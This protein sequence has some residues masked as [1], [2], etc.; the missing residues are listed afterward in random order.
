MRRNPV[1]VFKDLDSVGIYN[2]PLES[3]VQINDADANGD[4]L[5][6]QIEN[7]QGIGKTSTIRDFLQIEE[8]FTR[9]S[10]VGV[11]SDEEKGIPNGVAPLDDRALIP[12]RYI[13]VVDINEVYVVDSEAEMI[14][15]NANSG[16]M[17]IRTD[18]NET[19][20]DNGGTSNDITDWTLLTLQ[21]GAVQSV[22]GKTGNIVLDTDDINEG[23]TNKYF[24]SARFNS[25]FSGRKIGELNDVNVNNVG[26]NN[27]LLWSGNEWVAGAI[28]F[29][30][31][32]VNNKTGVIS[33]TT[34]DIPEDPNGNK[35]YR[36]SY[37]D[38]RIQNIMDDNSGIG[39]TDRLWSSDK[40]AREL[41]FKSTIDNPSFRGFMEITQNPNDIA[42][43]RVHNTGG[44]IATRV[45]SN[46]VF[47]RDLNASKSYGV[48]FDEPNTQVDFKM[49]TVTSF[50]IQ[51]N[52][53]PST[54][55]QPVEVNDLTRKDYVDGLID[56]KFNKTGGNISGDVNIG[57]YLT[58]NGGIQTGLGTNGSSL[59]SFTDSDN[60]AQKPGIYWSNTDK[61][62]K[63]TD[64]L[65]DANAASNEIWHEGNRLAVDPG[66]ITPGT[67]DAAVN[68]AKINQLLD[69]LRTAGIIG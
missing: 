19:Y 56:T 49:D 25:N 4:S 32:S 36:D 8:N 31:Q 61:Y 15:L 17:A 57:Q 38:T 45:N 40:T 10:T 11:V 52:R 63:I 12:G 3:M 27:T 55:H 58:V 50:S 53:A 60:D 26:T 23:L 6:I 43:L 68:E 1:Y 34:A 33:L 67:N 30:V 54:S 47:F 22:N 37:V 24:T 66:N 59:I 13:P 48:F 14:S 46:A 44:T 5:V 65:M 7:K 28:N 62:F 21:S 51:K 64:D 29:P 18:T 41:S 2:V 9:P 35:Y 16:D 69:N 20:I 39:D 42:E